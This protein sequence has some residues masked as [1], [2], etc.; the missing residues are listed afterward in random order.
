VSLSTLEQ[1]QATLMESILAALAPLPVR[2]I[3]TLGPA[4]AAARFTAPP[5]VMLERFVPHGSVLPRATAM[6]TQCGLGTVMKALAH[7]VALVC[8]PLVGDQAENAARIEALGAGVRLPSDA[9]PSRIRKAIEQ[10][11]TERRFRV[12]AQRFADA[13][14]GEDPVQAAVDEIQS[15]LVSL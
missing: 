6:I 11:L 7:G 8:I 14:A 13:V 4:L 15:V 2:A 1:G 9:D 5:N 12:A 10:V 3:V